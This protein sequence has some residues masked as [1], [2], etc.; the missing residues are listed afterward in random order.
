[1]ATAALRVLL[2]ATSLALAVLGVWVADRAVGAFVLPD[3]GFRSLVYPPH[4]EA[5]YDT[6]EFQFT[7]RTN[8]LGLRGPD[9]PLERG[10]ARRVLFLGDSYTFGWGVDNDEVWVR[11]VE[12]AL[13]ERGRDV[14]LANAGS[15][16]MRP[17]Q[18]AEFAE[19]LVPVLRPEL[20]V[21]GLLQGDDLRQSDADLNAPAGPALE[22][23][24]WRAAIR[25]FVP[26]LVE[27]V[28]RERQQRAA[29]LSERSRGRWNLVTQSW[30]DHAQRAFDALDAKGRARF[31]AI[32][33]AVQQAFLAGKLNPYLMLGF[34]LKLPP[35][36]AE[37]DLASPLMQRRIATVA[38]HLARLRR[39]A[40]QVGG[41]VIGLSIPH[42]MYASPESWEAL[43][44]LGR[45]S[46]P[47]ELTTDVPDRATLMA[48]KSAG[49]ECFAITEPFRERARQAPL[50]YPIDT[51]LN[52]AGNRVLA[53]LVTPL[54]EDALF[55]DASTASA[56]AAH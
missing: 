4:V 6:Y 40:E 52:T 17:R 2:L 25:R 18:Y 28:S 22:P 8:N 27:W 23:P 3:P 31:A 47:T 54:I 42:A 49:V 20:V 55:D 33:P 15:P 10:T 11:Q 21:V 12:R 1:V 26:H 30:K 14:E 36:E 13:R 34:A 7:A 35:A 48:C 24:G 37:L 16:G 50:F 39:A 53:E 5:F 32:D 29:A 51:H 9:L 19:E 56:R 44:K 43:R 41:R 46:D 45:P 38:P